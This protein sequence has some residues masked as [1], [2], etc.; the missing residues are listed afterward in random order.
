MIVDYIRFGIPPI[1]YPASLARVQ[2]AIAMQPGCCQ[3]KKYSLCTL[4]VLELNSDSFLLACCSEAVIE[5]QCQNQ[6]LG[7]M[8]VTIQDVSLSYSQKMLTQRRCLLSDLTFYRTN[9]RQ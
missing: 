1:V 5:P 2:V 3:Q 7:T 9:A 4:E 8:G 6:L